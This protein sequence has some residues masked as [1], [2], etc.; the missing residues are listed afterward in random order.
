MKHPAAVWDIA[1]YELYDMITEYI[2]VWIEQEHFLK[3][4]PAQI[5]WDVKFNEGRTG[6]MPLELTN[7]CE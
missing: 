4:I 3:L 7:T 5:G 6:H 2:R 1:Y